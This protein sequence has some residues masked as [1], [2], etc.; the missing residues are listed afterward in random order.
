VSNVF[1]ASAQQKFR[2]ASHVTFRLLDLNE[3][4]ADQGFEPHTFDVIVASD[5][6]HAT[7]SIRQSLRHVHQL[8]VPDGLFL[9]LELT[10]PSISTDMIWGLA[11]EWW[12]FSDHDLRGDYPLLTRE[13]WGR[14]LEDERVSDRAR[15]SGALLAVGAPNAHPGSSA[16]KSA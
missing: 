5:V 10:R 9:F 16:G 12:N 14:V 8:L 2:D 15:V 11:S 7:R 4:P 6:V 3:S 1:L 13:Q